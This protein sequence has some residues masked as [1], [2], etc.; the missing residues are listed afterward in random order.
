MERTKQLDKYLEKFKVGTMKITDTETGEISYDDIYDM[1]SIDIDE[2][3]RLAGR[4]T[5]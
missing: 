1:D 3:C 5:V 2:F 4:D